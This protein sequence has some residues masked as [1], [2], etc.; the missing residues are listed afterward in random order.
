LI[1]LAI[2]LHRYAMYPPEHPCL[3]RVAENMVARLAQ[4]FV[5]RH[6]LSIGVA[7]EQ[8]VIEGMATDSKQ[9]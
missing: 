4:Y 2:G 9:R 8:L 7:G 5:E 1:D 6:D 3:G